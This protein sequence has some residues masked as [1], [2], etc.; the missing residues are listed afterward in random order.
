VAF[1]LQ[2]RALSTVDAD[3]VRRI[4][5][6]E[7]RLWIGGVPDHQRGDAG[8]VNGGRDQEPGCRK[9]FSSS[10]RM[11]T[12]NHPR[13]VLPGLPRPKPWPPFW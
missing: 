5:P 9:P 1:I 2:D 6:G 11:K 13:L 12:S 10:Q 8:R 4:E 3:G 7:A